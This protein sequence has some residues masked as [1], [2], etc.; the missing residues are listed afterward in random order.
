MFEYKIIRANFA[1]YYEI[2]S[3][4]KFNK[5]IITDDD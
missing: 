3:D 2:G 1:I 4:E 5:L